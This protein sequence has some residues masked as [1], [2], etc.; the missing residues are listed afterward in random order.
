[1]RVPA[2]HARSLL[3]TWHLLR[4]DVGEEVFGL[5]SVGDHLTVLVDLVVVELLFVKL[6]V[7]LVPA[8]RDVI[9][10]VSGLL[11]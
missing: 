4:E 5:A 11:I 7:P 6:T 2:L 1:M 10:L 8:G 9:R 3:I